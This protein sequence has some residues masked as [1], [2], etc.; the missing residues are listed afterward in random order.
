MIGIFIMPIIYIICIIGMICLAI[1]MIR[2]GDREYVVA[3]FILL[4]L[5]LILIIIGLAALELFGII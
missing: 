4:F 5:D 3:G 2:E 1:S